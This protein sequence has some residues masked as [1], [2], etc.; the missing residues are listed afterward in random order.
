MDKKIKDDGGLAFLLTFQI[1]SQNIARIDGWHSIQSGGTQTITH[2][3]MSLR[4]WFAGQAL[5][6]VFVLLDGSKPKK[7]KEAAETAYAL[8]DA[9]L[10]QR[11]K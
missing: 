2:S 9:M 7:L 5:T 10:K 8:A 6:V 1:P 4:D 3:G 11:E